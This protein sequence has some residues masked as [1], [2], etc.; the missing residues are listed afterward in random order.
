MIMKTHMTVEELNELAQRIFDKFG[1]SEE[2]GEVMTEEIVEAQCRGLA[3]H[4]ASLIIDVV[5]HFRKLPPS[6]PIEIVKDGP[7]TAYIRGNGNIGSIV[8]KRA[9][10]MAME[11]AEA[12]GFGLVASSNIT[13]F[14]IGSYN[15][16]RAAKRGLIGVN[17]TATAGPG[18]VAP[19][20]SM[21]HFLSVDPISIA[22]PT[23][24]EPIVL[25]MTWIAAGG[26]PH[27]TLAAYQKL[28][29]PLPS[30]WALDKDGKPTTDA[31]TAIES[32]TILPIGGARGSGFMIMLHLLA[33]ALVGEQ[34]ENET[35]EYTIE[36]AM[37]TTI[38]VAAKPDVF[39]SRELFLNTLSLHAATITKARPRPGFK[40]VLLPGQRGDKARRVSLEK[41]FPILDVVL[42][43]KDTEEPYIPRHVY[44]RLMGML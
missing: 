23:A 2:E 12:T 6:G 32:G 25:D 24:N 9:M 13:P 30:D 4:G 7:S 17:W 21:D 37:T 8:S 3:S 11:K 39:V 31:T 10:D 43:D 5:E 40:E 19:H 15:P 26:A 35:G 36:G 20:G 1:F 14:L 34:R 22:V 33:Q 38:H 27:L 28:G 44:D 42:Q 18:E 41:G 29:T 16:L